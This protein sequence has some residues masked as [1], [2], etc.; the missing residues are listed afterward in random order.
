VP[1]GG[2]D[3][4]NLTDYS[5][6]EP[7]VSPDGKYLSC[8]TGAEGGSKKNVIAVLTFDGGR[9]LKT[10]HLPQTTLI[11]M[12]P[13]WT[14]DGRGLT[15]VDAHGDVSNLWL[16]PVSGGRPKQVTNYKQGN[17]LRREWSRDGKRV[18]IVRASQTSDAVTIT[19]F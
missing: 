13:I 1:L 15:Y 11:D 19:G 8:F 4:Q 12:S 17:I 14:P 3:A 6:T 16:Q 7:D 9:P 2:G 5:A 10:F 18:A